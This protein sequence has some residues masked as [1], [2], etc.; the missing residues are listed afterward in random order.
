MFKTQKCPIC[1]LNCFTHEK[2]NC[3][4]HGTNSNTVLTKWSR[5]NTAES[6]NEL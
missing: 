6:N 3:V 1:K 2:L 5:N 4:D